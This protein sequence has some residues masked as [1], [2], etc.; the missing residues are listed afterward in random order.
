[1]QRLCHALS[2]VVSQPPPKP[3]R[4][5]VLAV[6]CHAGFGRCGLFLITLKHLK[7]SPRSIVAKAPSEEAARQEAEDSVVRRLSEVG[8][9]GPVREVAGRRPKDS[10][11]RGCCR[12]QAARPGPRK[13]PGRRPR[14]AVRRLQRNSPSPV[15]GVAGGGRKTQS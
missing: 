1:M 13:S 15:E 2:G 11:V 6:D 10:V 7:L 9:A 4:T 3:V 5:A 8:A 14:P 12:A